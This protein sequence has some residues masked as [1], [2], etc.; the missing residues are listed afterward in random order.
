MIDLKTLK[1]VRYSTL[2]D[3]ETAFNNSGFSDWVWFEG[4]AEEDLVRY[5]YINSDDSKSLT[6]LVKEYL[7]KNE[8]NV[9]DYFKN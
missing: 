3:A 7:V 8:Q 6:D 4:F 2:L 1:N 9:S 5:L